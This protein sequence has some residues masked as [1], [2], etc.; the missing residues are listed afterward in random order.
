MSRALDSPDHMLLE[1]AAR[2]ARN[3]SS[4]HRNCAVS[5]VLDRSLRIPPALKSQA[6]VRSQIVP[7]SSRTAE[8]SSRTARPLRRKTAGSFSS[9]AECSH[10]SARARG[11]ASSF[12][13]FVCVLSAFRDP[14]TLRLPFAFEAFVVLDIPFALLCPHQSSAGDAVGKPLKPICFWRWQVVVMAVGYLEA[15]SPAYELRLPIHQDQQAETGG[16]DERQTQ[17]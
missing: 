3:P 8:A 10:A 6:L 9:A 15:A 16:T 13:E 4:F 14:R 12:S 5:K 2:N 11:E 17:R 1:C 7:R